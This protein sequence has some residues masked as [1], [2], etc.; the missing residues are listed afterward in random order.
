MC[1]SADRVNQIESIINYARWR[2]GALRSR[3]T[4]MILLILL[5][6]SAAGCGTE[7]IDTKKLVS[8]WTSGGTGTSYETLM[9]FANGTFTKE[10]KEESAASPGVYRTLFSARGKWEESS[11]ILRL[12]SDQNSATKRSEVLWA[13]G[14]FQWELKE[15]GMKLHLKRP[16]D[17]QSFVYRRLQ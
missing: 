5:A 4:P 11:G 1:E 2:T 3:V 14:S 6:V 12:I 10:L 17:A 15:S 8:I 16:G 7:K 13:Y 9:L